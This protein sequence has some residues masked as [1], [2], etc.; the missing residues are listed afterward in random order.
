MTSFKGYI[1]A[2]GRR[3]PQERQ[4]LLPVVT[5]SREAGAGAVSVG[6]LVASRLNKRQGR[7]ADC[8]WTIFDR[9][10]VEKVL[11][12]HDLPRRIRRFMPEDTIHLFQDALEEQLG[13]HPSNWTLVQHT[14]ETI[15]HLAH[16][17]NAILVGRGANMVTAHLTNALHVRLVAPVDWRIRHVAEYFEFTEKEATRYVHATDAARRRYVRRNFGVSVEDP[18]HYDLVINTGQLGF[19][20]AARLVVQALSRL[21]K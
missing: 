8:P 11:E 1:E 20:N 16:L 3:S 14:A 2:Q 6:R 15:L 19:E 7:E 21:P 12:D 18:L 13:L 9:N 17:G 10:L 5:V 4:T